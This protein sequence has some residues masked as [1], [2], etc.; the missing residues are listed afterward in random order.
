ME[1]FGDKLWCPKKSGEKLELTLTEIEKK[2]RISKEKA[3]A[4]VLDSYFNPS[5]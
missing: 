2:F 5:L 1:A 3:L 4:I